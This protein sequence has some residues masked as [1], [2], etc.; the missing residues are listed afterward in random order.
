MK[1]TIALAAASMIAVA[2]LAAPSFAEDAMKPAA[3]T[4][5]QSGTTASP[6]A[7]TTASTTAEVDTSALIAAIGANQTSV[8]QIPTITDVSKLKVV[9]VS[10]IATADEDKTKLETAL[11]ENKEQVTALQTAVDANAAL[12][13]ELEKQQVEASSVVATKMEADGSMTV[14]VQ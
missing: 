12:K 6:D 9:K 11:S 8:T 2:G 7:A 14:F 10:D 1:R 5:T 3:G 4:E 13:A